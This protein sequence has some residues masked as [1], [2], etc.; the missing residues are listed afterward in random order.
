MDRSASK[1]LQEPW[2][3][4]RGARRP[5][6]DPPAGREFP[7]KP[8]PPPTSLELQAPQLP[9]RHACENGYCGVGGS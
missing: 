8:T 6:R 3:P 4:I 1:Q 9:E 2:S 7:W 5:G